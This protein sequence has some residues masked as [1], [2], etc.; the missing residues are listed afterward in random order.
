MVGKFQNDGLYPV[1][2]I[3]ILLAFS[4]WTPY[5]FFYAKSRQTFSI[6][7]V[8]YFPAHH[9]FRNKKE[10]RNQEGQVKGC[11]LNSRLE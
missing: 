6:D 11:F 1:P 10:G 9:R 3:G 5:Y 4:L 8:P 7:D 2:L